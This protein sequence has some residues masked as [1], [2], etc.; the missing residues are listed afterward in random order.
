MCA[1]VIMINV[2]VTIKLYICIKKGVSTYSSFLVSIGDKEDDVDGFDD[3]SKS[4]YG[5]E[6]KG[7][8]I[9]LHSVV[10]PKHRAKKC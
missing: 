3:A 1:C 8:A 4:V 2:K 7:C 10:N 5:D 9:F 6:K